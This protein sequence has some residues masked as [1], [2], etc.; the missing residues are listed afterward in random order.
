[1]LSIFV[2]IALFLVISI[3]VVAW[4]GLRMRQLANDGVEAEARVLKKIRFRGKSGVPA[5]RIRYAYSAA[6]GTP[7]ERTIALTEKEAEVYREGGVINIT[8]QRSNPGNSAASSMVVLARQ[9]LQ[10]K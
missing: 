10:K 9:A 1:M 8:Y 4:R 2:V 5:Y 6:D 3:G 7:H